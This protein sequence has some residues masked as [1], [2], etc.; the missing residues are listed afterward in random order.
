[1][2]SW[3]T[4]YT[5]Y[6]QIIL[7][8]FYF[9]KATATLVLVV[10]L[11]GLLTDCYVIPSNQHTNN[12]VITEIT[13]SDLVQVISNS[14]SLTAQ[15]TEIRL[16]ST[17]GE[18]PETHKRAVAA[19]T[20]G[21]TQSSGLTILVGGPDV[22][23]FVGSSP[24]LSLLAQAGISQ[25]VANDTEEASV[26]DIPHYTHAVCPTSPT[27]LP[28]GSIP[29]NERSLCPWIYVPHTDKNRHP[30]TMSYAQCFCPEC[31]QHNGQDFSSDGGCRPIIYDVKVLRKHSC[32]NGTQIYQS[33]YEKVP[34]ACTCVRPQRG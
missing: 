8:V 26:D 18:T 20:N 3:Y 33:D 32:R 25:C 27:L 34:V 10:F 23:A 7:C 31:I 13:A 21:S 22:E 29:L 15:G 30:Q 1:M 16:P 19:A 6:S 24:L 4:K 2:I 9:L 5:L 17:N 11:N 12:G 28:Q 14:E